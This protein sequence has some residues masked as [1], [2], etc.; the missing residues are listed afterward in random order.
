MHGIGTPIGDLLQQRSVTYVL[1]PAAMY[2]MLN[3]IM[4]PI[5]LVLRSC[6]G[7]R[8]SYGMLIWVEVPLL[9]AS[10]WC[11]DT[12][13]GLWEKRAESAGVADAV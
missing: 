6:F 7:F 9:V 10:K 5:W 1:G 3:G 13:R 11:R 2:V 8:M 12:L 4:L